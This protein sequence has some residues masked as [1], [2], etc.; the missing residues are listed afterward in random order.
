MKS[1]P[2]YLTMAT[3]LLVIII[4]AVTSSVDAFST[5]SQK[6]RQL[7][8]HRHQTNFLVSEH[9]NRITT[10][11]LYQQPNFGDWT[12]DDFLNSLS[13]G[14]DNQQQ[15]NYNNQYG[16][17]YDENYNNEQF[18]SYDEA[19]AHLQ[20]L[21]QQQQ[22][23]QQQVEMTDEEITEWAMRAAQ[24]YN[25]ESSVQEAYGM[26]APKPPREDEM[27]GEY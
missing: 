14:G 2:A 27:G 5:T 8:S 26:S 1:S 18:S 17:D 6:Q 24:F 15:Q 19:K 7:T 11:C 10:S 4:A 12:N 21:Q 9:N 20:Q 22:Q 23:Q 25:T 3:T 13:G 16:G